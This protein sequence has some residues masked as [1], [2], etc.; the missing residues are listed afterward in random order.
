VAEGSLSPTP[1]VI[2]SF[3]G[4]EGHVA[5]VLIHVRGGR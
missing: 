5:G 3:S 1:I 4:I 2:V